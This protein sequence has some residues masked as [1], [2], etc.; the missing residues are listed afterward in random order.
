MNVRAEDISHE[1]IQ[2]LVGRDA[3]LILEI[4]ANDGEDTLQFLAGFPSAAVHC[5]ECDPR[6]ISKW[7]D[8]FPR[9]RVILDAAGVI[10]QVQPTKCRA[11]LFEIALDDTPGEKTF[12]QSGGAA[13]SSPDWDKS[14]SLCKPTGHLR[15]SPEITFNSRISVMSMRLDDWAA[16]YLPKDGVIDFIW[17]DCQGAER[18]VLS[19]GQE[20]LRRTRFLKAECHRGELYEGQPTEAEMFAML[21]GWTCL[22][23]WADDLILRNDRPESP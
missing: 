21:P 23:R 6:A 5:F 2:R 3:K 19:A 17:I 8:R 22:G 1:E 11:R 20:T 13:G 9:N 18:R 10:P 15:R 4:G 12:H 16:A 14:G 7:R